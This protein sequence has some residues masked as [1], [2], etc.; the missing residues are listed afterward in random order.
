MAF[1]LPF[2]LSVNLTL[3][4][5]WCCERYPAQLK[6]MHI[7]VMMN[8]ITKWSCQVGDSYFEPRRLRY[9]H[10]LLDKSQTTDS[11][12]FPTW[13]SAFIRYRNQTLMLNTAQSVLLDLELAR[14]SIFIFF[15]TSRFSEF[16][17]PL[18]S[19]SWEILAK[20]FLIEKY[21]PKVRECL[22]DLSFV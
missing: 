17:A 12:F 2:L 22:G 18:C 14:L 19:S 3:P 11:S 4:T 16:S 21:W 1:I 7:Q 10:L 5:S 8:L 20:G 13:H 6:S 9:K 15:P